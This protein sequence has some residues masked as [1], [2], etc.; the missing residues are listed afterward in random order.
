MFA[1][2]L[3]DAMELR[4]SIGQAGA[5]ASLYRDRQFKISEYGFGLKVCIVT[6]QQS[7]KGIAP[8]SQMQCSSPC[9]EP[10]QASSTTLPG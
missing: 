10:L 5:R 8:L 4:D 1:V 7:L 3:Q 2:V 6:G 9:L